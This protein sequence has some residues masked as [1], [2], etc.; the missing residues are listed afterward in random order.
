MFIRTKKVKRHVYA[1][2]VKNRWTKDGPRQRVARYLGR[3][4]EAGAAGE[5]DFMA[6]ATRSARETILALVAWQLENHGFSKK[7]KVWS[8]DDVTVDLERLRT[9]HVIRMN[10]DYLC[11][12]TLRRLARFKSG[13]D[14]AGVGMAFAKAFVSAGIPVPQDVFV[15][16]FQE[17]YKPGQS[18]VP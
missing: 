3:V 6:G 7:G 5:R 2:V 9:S 11:D 4:Y 13:R 15:N 10:N 16:L 17:I 1:Y 14:E 8:K 12:Y 18:Y